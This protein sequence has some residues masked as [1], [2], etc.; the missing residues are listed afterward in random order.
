MFWNKKDDENPEKKVTPE[1]PEVPQPAVR[2]FKFKHIKFYAATESFADEKKYYRKVIEQ[3][4]V[5]YLNWEVALYNK[6]FDEADWKGAIVTRCYKVDEGKKEMCNIT[7]ELN[8]TKDIDIYYYRYSW[9][10]DAPGYWVA[11][12]Y[13]WEVYI[14]NEL[15]GTETMYINYFGLVTETNNPYFDLSAVRL[16][17]SYDDFRESKEGYRY[18]T[19]FDANITEYVG[20]EIE[21]KRKQTVSLNYEFIYYINKN[22]STPKALFTNTSVLPAGE[23]GK[24]EYIRYAWGVPKPGY[25]K[26]GNYFVYVNFMGQKIAS[27]VFSVGETEIAGT[28]SLL[29]YGNTL[30]Q[31]QPNTIT[32]EPTKTTED[33][34]KE[35]DTLVGM[36]NVKKS[37][38]ENIS[39]LQFNKIRIDKG[40]KD[41]SAINL[42]SVF[43]GNPGTGKT[44][45]VRLLGQIYHSMGLLSKGHVVEAGRAELIAEYIGQTAPKVKKA[46]NDAR[47]GMLFIDE[48]YALTREDDKQDFG[49]EAIEILM[50]EM[51]DGPGDIAI[52]AAG[53]P[54]E[55][56]IFLNSNPG[57]KSRFKQ[58]FNFE[59][60]LPEEL[61]E[62]AQVALQKEETTLDDNARKLL[63][64]YITEQYRNRDRSFGNAR[65]MYG[66][67]D[68]AKKQM[69]LRLLKNPDIES[70]GKEELSTITA[71]DLQA[72]FTENNRRKLTLSIE[73]KELKD[74]LD[75]LNELIGLTQIKKEISDTI[76]LVRFYSETGK[77]VLNKFSLHAVL[78]GNP[79]TGKTT[80]A[81]L[82]GKIY[83]ALGLLERGHLVEVDRQGLVAGYVGHTAIKTA[84]IINQ[85][86]GGVL[87]IDEAYALSQG[88]ENDFGQEAI[89]TILKS[90]E[91]NRGQFAVIAA[92]YTDN[93]DLFL[94]S[95]PGLKSRFD[96]MYNLP[97]YTVAEMMEIAQLL[98]S[99]EN[100][101]PDTG[102]ENYLEQ[103][104]SSCYE[105]RD[106][107]FGNARAIR[108]AVESVI[109]QQNLRLAAIPSAQRTNEML[110]QILLEDVNH[111]PL[112]A[113]QKPS[114]IGFKK[115]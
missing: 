48:A 26:K 35:L 83:K 2:N 112:I 80:L 29:N 16:Y 114:G 82:M 51:S 70:L 75:E 24:T 40:F 115:S 94:K 81:R 63:N 4:E 96:K 90:M 66:I 76:N 67:I 58:Y 78:T 18:A 53:Y 27:A 23:M 33:L 9:G 28:P 68:E 22:E 5:T 32:A 62:I 93:M 45:V 72:I 87:F 8:V 79:G 7:A 47:G 20:V 36:E 44:T 21:I 14:D 6:K 39:Y 85:A 111:L 61:M 65:L 10:T 71:E 54:A 15:A 73:E 95:N 91:D 12:I 86:M 55:M 52:V 88:G 42:H 1:T 109:M 17:P 37:I 84:N 107:Y 19:Q 77:D 31:T 41:D 105:T 104:F 99:K 74:T 60:Y 38:K 106:R 25:W 46:I 69:G 103:Y 49:Q 30:S 13:S 3:E 59:D 64:N 92:G 101:S 50:K 108:Q 100:L 57:L 43:T 56:Q 102:A 11:G 98:F 34:L 110:A 113:V 97:D 89:E